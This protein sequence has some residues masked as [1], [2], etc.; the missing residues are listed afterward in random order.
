MKKLKYVKTFESFNYNKLNETGEWI[1]DAEGI[2]WKDSL[3]S[4][5][6]EIKDML[7][8]D[9]TFEIKNVNGFDKYQGPYAD[10]KIND[11]FYTIWFAEGDDILYVEYF[12]VSNTDPK[13]E[14]PGFIGTTVD[15]AD[16][17]NDYFSKDGSVQEGKATELD[18]CVECKIKAEKAGAEKFI[19][20]VGEILQYEN[21]SYLIELDE[22]VP[23]KN[24]AISYKYIKKCCDCVIKFEKNG[25]HN[26]CIFKDGK[27]EEDNIKSLKQAEEICKDL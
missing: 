25:I 2:A 17:I 19:K 4:A 16:V 12:P 13:T 8:S 24:G 26:Y 7:N 15:I 9:I 5:V 23:L 6:E 14:K 1:D 20:K 22:F 3:R 10:V 11:K 21:G 27:C 18:S